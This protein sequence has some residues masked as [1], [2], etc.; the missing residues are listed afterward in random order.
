MKPVQVGQEAYEGLCCS[1][2]TEE[3]AR[4]LKTPVDIK[5]ML[6]NVQEA[7][8]GRQQWLLIAVGPRRKNRSRFILSRCDAAV[9]ARPFR[10]TVFCPLLRGAASWSLCTDLCYCWWCLMRAI[11]HTPSGILPESRGGHALAFESCRSSAA[12]STL[13]TVCIGNCQQNHFYKPTD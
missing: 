3:V 6:R 12:S 4:N 1:D 9:A 10:L 2:W 5:L 11:A 8:T 7:F 13:Q